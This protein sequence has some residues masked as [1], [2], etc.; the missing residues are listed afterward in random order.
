MRKILQAAKL[1]CISESESAH[2]AHPTELVLVF[3][4]P[5]HNIQAGDR[6]LLHSKRFTITMGMGDYESAIVRRVTDGTCGCGRGGYN[7]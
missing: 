4:D 3:A 5:A 1:E 7:F 2:T 6:C